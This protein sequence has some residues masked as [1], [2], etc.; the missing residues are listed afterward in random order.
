MEH[1]EFREFYR[2]CFKFNRE[3]IQ[4]KTLEKDI[5][6]GYLPMI[7]GSRSKYT[8]SFVE[9]LQQAPMSRVSTDE[10]NSFLEFSREFDGG[11]DKFADDG[12][13]PTLLDDFVEWHRA[14]K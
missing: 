8:E 13:W 5:V 1:K 4:K 10:W 12:A 6:T 11:L 14:K 2:F 7:V 9:F 3:D